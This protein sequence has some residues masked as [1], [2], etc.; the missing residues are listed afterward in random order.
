MECCTITADD[1]FKC[2]LLFKDCAQLSVKSVV[3][4]RH[5]LVQALSSARRMAVAMCIGVCDVCL[6]QCGFRM[7]VANGM[8][9]ARRDLSCHNEA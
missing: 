4:Y 6:K 5:T 9:A 7:A 3:A 1:F 2:L 8:Q